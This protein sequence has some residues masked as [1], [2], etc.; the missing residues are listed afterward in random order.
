MLRLDLGNNNI[1]NVDAVC[2]CSELSE[3][4]IDQ[5]RLSAL[6]A[7]LPA[8]LPGLAKLS[9]LEAGGNLV[10]RLPGELHRLNSLGSLHLQYN[11]LT[12]LPALLPPSLVTLNLHSNRLAALPP[13]VGLCIGLQAVSTEQP[14]LSGV[15]VHC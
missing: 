5:N 12:H 13:G 11:R 3:L 6:P 2:G 14:A 15:R 1:V 10:G 4:W 8:A 9:F 7:A